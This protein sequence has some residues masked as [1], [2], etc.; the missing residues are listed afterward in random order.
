[1]QYLFGLVVI[2]ALGNVVIYRIELVAKELAGKP[3]AESLTTDD[4]SAIS[5]LSHS[6]LTVKKKRT[7]KKYKKMVYPPQSIPD[8]SGIVTSR[9]GVC[10]T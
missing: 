8:P 6:Q 9:T 5:G 4:S 2:T 3:A 7:I 1:M 10:F